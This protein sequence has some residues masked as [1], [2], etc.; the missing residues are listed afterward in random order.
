M[1][2]IEFFQMGG[3]PYEK[4]QPAQ[5]RTQRE[6]LIPSTELQLVVSQ[7]DQTEEITSIPRSSVTF[8]LSCSA[9]GIIGTITP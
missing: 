8:A 3:D 9:N 7:H 6:G 1:S 4:K 5:H 2:D